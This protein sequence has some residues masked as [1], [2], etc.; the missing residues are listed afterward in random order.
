[1]SLIIGLVTEDNVLLAAD[2]LGVRGNGFKVRSEGKVWRIGR[3]L[4]GIT[5][6]LDR[7]NEIKYVLDEP[8]LVEDTY[9]AVCQVSQMVYGKCRE[10]EKDEDLGSS[11]VALD[12]KLY[13][14][15]GWL[16]VCDCSKE[17]YGAAGSGQEFVLGFIEGLDTEWETEDRALAVVNETMRQVM[18]K[19]VYVGGPVEL[20]WLGGQNDG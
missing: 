9:G 11:L 13:Y 19:N 7:M 8:E 5:G 3:A 1:M 18:G 12:G 15:A 14:V 20:H 6:S 16:D 4:V 17:G 10:E 2:S